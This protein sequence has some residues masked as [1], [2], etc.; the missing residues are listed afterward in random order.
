MLADAGG[1]LNL[2]A[3]LND[4]EDDDHDNEDDDDDDDHDDEDDD[5]NDDGLVKTFIGL[6]IR[7][8]D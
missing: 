1:V 3:L 5:D 4:D 6:P 2:V 8:A 7:I